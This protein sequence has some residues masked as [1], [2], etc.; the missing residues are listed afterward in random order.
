MRIKLLPLIFLTIFLC[1]CYRNYEVYEFKST[2]NHYEWGL[3]GAKLIG[4][5]ELKRNTIVESSPYKLLIWFDSKELPNK[6][7]EIKNIKLVYADSLKT[8]FQKENIHLRDAT[9]VKH[10]KY[11]SLKYLELEY[12]NIICYITFLYQEDTEIIEYN[13]DFACVTMRF[14][15]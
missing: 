10:S 9:I 12:H 4:N 1:S 14:I 13:L 2:E 3:V 5:K 11:F 6:V 7:I 15:N 8:A